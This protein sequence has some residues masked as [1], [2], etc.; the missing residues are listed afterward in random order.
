[1]RLIEPTSKL[2]TIKLLDRYFNIAYPERTIY[3]KIFSIGEKKEKIEAAAVKCAKEMLQEDLA[4]I[5][6]DV[7]TLYFETF[8]GVN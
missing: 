1:M 3:R 2:R 8:K 7:T 6:Y 5:L 4:L